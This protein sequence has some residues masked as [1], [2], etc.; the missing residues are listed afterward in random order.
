METVKV[1]NG[2]NGYYFN[3]PWE[4]NHYF[5]EIITGQKPRILIAD[6]NWVISE[7]QEVKEFDHK[8]LMMVYTEIDHIKY[9]AIW[10]SMC[11]IIESWGDEEKTQ[12]ARKCL[13]WSQLQKASRI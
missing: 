13:M 6:Q 2:F 7:D 3:F 1:E 4:P 8:A 9:K 10:G 12:N 5:L 11:Q